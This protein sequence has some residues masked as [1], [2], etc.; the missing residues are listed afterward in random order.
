MTWV[1]DTASSHR[2]HLESKHNPTTTY[3]LQHLDQGYVVD[4]VPLHASMH[5]KMALCTVLCRTFLSTVQVVRLV[6][7][8]P[9][10]ICAIA[11][12]HVYDMYVFVRV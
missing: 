12:M 7:Q 4:I 3:L 9:G 5:L 2:R 11:Y 10:E 6:V 1:R 8:L